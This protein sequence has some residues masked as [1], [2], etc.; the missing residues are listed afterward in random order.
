MKD[1]LAAVVILVKEF[2][3][4]STAIIPMPTA[5]QKQGNVVYYKTQNLFVKS[6]EDVTIEI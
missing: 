6:T 5:K 3:Q 4:G 2:M 1:T